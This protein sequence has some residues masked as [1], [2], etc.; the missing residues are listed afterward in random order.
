MVK[1]IFIWSGNTEKDGSGRMFFFNNSLVHKE[2]QCHLENEKIETRSLFF[3][4]SQLL[5]SLT[6]HITVQRLNSCLYLSC[7]NP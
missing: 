3:S 4:D 7:K 2:N 6:L 1:E 5:K